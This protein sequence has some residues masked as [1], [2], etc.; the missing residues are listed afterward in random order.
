MKGFLR[1]V[2]FV[3][4]MFLAVFFLLLLPALL[5]GV[6]ARW[7]V[8][9]LAVL[10]FLFLLGPLWPAMRYGRFSKNDETPEVKRQFGWRMSTILGIYAMHWIAVLDF[11]KGLWLFAKPSLVFLSGVD[12]TWISALGLTLVATGGIIAASAVQTLGVFF[13]RLIIK[14][15]HHLVTNGLYSLVRH[16]VYLAYIFLY[17]GVCIAMQSL[18]ALGVLILFGV[19]WFGAHIEIEEALLAKHFGG[20]FTAYQQRTKKLFPFIY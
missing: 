12:T 7:E 17:A 15:K 10:Y 16:P 8:I 4:Q 1:T 20:A 9:T 5:T 19:P 6:A 18:V 3:R 2:R 14:E 13:D 11:S